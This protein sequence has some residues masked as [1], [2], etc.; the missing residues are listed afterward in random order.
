MYALDSHV[1]FWNSS[2]LTEDT[3]MEYLPEYC[4]AFRIPIPSA[5]EKAQL[6]KHCWSEHEDL[7]STSGTPREKHTSSAVVHL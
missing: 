4:A 5:E 3:G 6:M 2:L 7:N 1:L